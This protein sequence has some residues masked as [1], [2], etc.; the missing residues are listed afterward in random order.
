MRAH[1]FL[2]LVLIR[3]SSL[4]VF[5]HVALWFPAFSTQRES[6]ADAA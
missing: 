5:P 4:Y 6:M 1:A 3:S 2:Y